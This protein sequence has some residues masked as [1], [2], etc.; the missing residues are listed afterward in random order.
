M[1]VL[2]QI[3]RKRQMMTYT[4]AFAPFVLLF[5]PVSFSYG[6]H[7]LIAFLRDSI[8]GSGN[9]SAKKSVPKAVAAANPPNPADATKAAAADATEGTAVT[10]ETTEAATAENAGESAPM[11]HA[12]VAVSMK[13]DSEITEVYS[14]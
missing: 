8:L 11:S 1:D 4:V 12:M 3:M 7:M 2:L 5:I 10:G 14:W 6:H 9:H 13:T